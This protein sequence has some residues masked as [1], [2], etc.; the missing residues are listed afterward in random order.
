MREANM[1][2]LIS[3]QFVG[4]LALLCSTAGMAATVNVTPSNATPLVSQS[5]TV[6]ISGVSFPANVG[7]SLGLTFDATKVAYV[8]TALPAT[9]PYSSG[10][11]AFLTLFPNVGT[12]TDIF[13]TPAG[14][15]SG[16]FDA[17]IITFQAIAV[18][19]ANIKIID[20]C[21]TTSGGYPASCSGGETR[22]WFD[23]VNF[24]GI[25]AAYN[26]ANVTVTAAVPVPAAAWLLMSALGSI[27]G[28]KRL[29]RQ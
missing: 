4:I 1:K 9:G 12:P 11:G 14:S 28:L 26:Q 6:T 23:D 3:K 2:K 15:P 8:S 22:A 29:R 20:D 7:P 13:V 18:G 5:F 10:A 21:D 17:F 24:L 16:S 19:A 25:P 27:A